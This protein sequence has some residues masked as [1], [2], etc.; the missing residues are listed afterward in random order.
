MQRFAYSLVIV[1]AGVSS[2]TGCGS[3]RHPLGKVTGTVTFEGEP[4]REGSIVF[5]VPG[6]R[7]ATGKIVDG[8]ITEVTTFDPNDGAPVGTAKIAVHAFGQ[9]PG[10]GSAVAAHPGD[11]QTAD[12]SGYMGVQ[13]S[14]IPPHYNDPATSGLSYE[15]TGGENNVTLELKR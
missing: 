8:R 10:E 3:A 9:S 5:E 14:L 2:L 6:M 13:S 15:I 12:M 1:L 7:S 11:V 4:V